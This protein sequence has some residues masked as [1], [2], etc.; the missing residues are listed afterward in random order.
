MLSESVVAPLLVFFES[1][2][3]FFILE[4]EALLRHGLPSDGA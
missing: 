1:F 3:P 2:L 4:E